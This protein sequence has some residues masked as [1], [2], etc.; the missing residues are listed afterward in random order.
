VSDRMLAS[1]RPARPVSGSSEGVG[2]GLRPHAG[3]LHDQTH[4]GCVWSH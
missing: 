2:V 1:T 3:S 4:G